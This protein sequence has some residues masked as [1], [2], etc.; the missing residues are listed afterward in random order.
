MNSI[1]NTESNRQNC[2][3]SR[4]DING[5]IPEMKEPNDINESKNDGDKN[6]KTN[7]EVCQ[8]D[9]GNNCYASQCKANI[10]VHLFCYDFF[11][12]P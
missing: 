3:T 2:S 9:G 8:H 6:H 12:L 7:C 11:H 4:E 1:I 5:D 10:S